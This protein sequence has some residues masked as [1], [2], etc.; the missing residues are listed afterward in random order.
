MGDDP[1]GARSCH[2]DMEPK[3]SDDTAW[4]EVAQVGSSLPPLDHLRL[5]WLQ[6][7]VG[8]WRRRFWRRP[9]LPP[10]LTAQQI[11]ARVAALRVS[12]WSYEFEPG[13][14]HLGPMAQDFAGA[15]GLGRTN[16]MIGEVDAN[17]IALVA[18]QVLDRR[19]RELE[20]QVAVLKE[21]Q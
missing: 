18:I 1:A 11:M 3:R 16:R 14:R 4:G 17:G 9:T 13:V 5:I 19:V 2:A 12:T 15:F 6:R 10:P 8:P 21:R 7:I 20:E